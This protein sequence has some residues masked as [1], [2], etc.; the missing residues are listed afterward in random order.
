M[1]EKKKILVRVLERKVS[2][3]GGFEDIEANVM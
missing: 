2:N 1:F 3:G